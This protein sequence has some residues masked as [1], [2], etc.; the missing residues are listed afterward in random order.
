MADDHWHA[1]RGRAAF[2]R[3]FV[4]DLRPYIPEGFDEFWHGNVDEAE[5]APLDYTIEPAPTVPTPGT[6]QTDPGVITTHHEIRTFTF[7]GI[8]GETL[9]G[10]IATPLGQQTNKAPGFL[11]IAPYG[12]ESVMPN[13]YGTREGFVSLSFNFFGLPAFHQ[14]K[15]EPS[16]GYFSDGVLDK[17][18]WIFSRMFQNAV[19]ASRVL[20]DLPQADPHRLGAMGM[21]QGGGISIWL[22]AWTERIKAVCADMPFLGAMHETLMKNIYRY[23]LKELMDFMGSVP[24][25]EQRVLRTIGYFDTLNQAARCG[26]PT[27]VSL[28]LKDPA[29]KPIQAEAIFEALPGVKALERYDT[30][31]GTT[32]IRTWLKTIVAGLVAQASSLYSQR[33]KI[34]AGSLRYFGTTLTNHELRIV[35]VRLMTNSFRILFA[36]TLAAIAT[37]ANAKDEVTWSAKLDRA[38]VRAGE[39]ARV[40]I[41]AKIAEGYHAYSIVPVEM[42]GPFPTT[43]QPPTGDGIESAGPI[44]E[45]KP[46]IEEDPNF[47]KEVGL[48][49]GSA[50][51]Y[52]PI[53]IKPGQSGS[54]SLT[55]KLRFMACNNEHCLPPANVEVPVTLSVDPGPARP[56][57]TKLAS[58]SSSQTPTSGQATDDASLQIKKAQDAGLIPFMIFA[59]GM[60]LLSLLTP[61]VF[62]MIPIT[63]SFFSKQK[64]EDQKLSFAGPLAYCFGIIATF[65]GLG[66]II[67]STGLNKVATNPW[68]NFALATLFIVLAASLFGVFEIRLPSWLINKANAKS[69]SGGLV[70]PLVMGLTFTMTSF[71]CTVPFVGTLLAQ[72]AQNGLTYSILGMLA[73]STAFAL[74]FFLLAL[75]P[76]FL[77]KL[78]RSGAWLIT[79][80]AYMGYLELMAALKFLSNVDLAFSLGW[81]TRPVFLAIW[82]I[83]AAVGG[84]YML[85]WLRL[86]HDADGKVGWI[87]RGFGVATLGLAVLCLAGLE[88][89][90]L[91]Q[92]A[93]FLPPD[94]YPGHA[95]KERGNL[96]WESTYEGAIAKARASGKNV[97]IDFTGIYCTNCRLIEE[98]VFP[99][100]EVEKELGKFVLARLYTDRGIPETDA[101][102]KL[103]VQMT[104]VNTLPIYVVVTPEGKVLKV[105]QQQPPLEDAEKLLAA[106]K[107]YSGSVVAMKK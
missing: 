34:Q 40:V 36:L 55:V 8:S 48:F 77:A 4:S 42:P 43:I 31:A 5:V 21:S 59:F 32:G 29:V 78:P 106:I 90:N 46:L 67:G 80:K 9:N 10:W 75:F 7:R 22:G 27:H 38:D 88:G 17:E 49:T 92:L 28:G 93:A 30:I 104:S 15:Y 45:Q 26:K 102:Q 37:L 70:G 57:F 18:S 51:F 54:Q 33:L 44:E 74:P 3:R 25:G 1:H 69:R 14:E 47:G 16:R 98:N 35:C 64:G 63:V 68:V 62:P 105:H 23:P 94:P 61:C 87:R 65:T 72:S 91:G 60:G 96:T 19:I 79:V 82:A 76:S 95:G 86:P 66:V 20:A 101:N 107:P 24:D 13:Q 73:Y 6:G 50:E 85:G 99:R 41:T 56:E 58:A 84:L 83:I 52:A 81:L 100:P 2:R 89:R 71:T 53:R 103:Q 11:W 39:V 12:R 97:F